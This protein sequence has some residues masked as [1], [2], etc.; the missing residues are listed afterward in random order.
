MSMNIYYYYH[1][2]IIIDVAK[3][4]YKNSNLHNMINSHASS[5]IEITEI[6]VGSAQF[7]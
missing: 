7:L 4:I 5:S 1:D 6:D 3:Q 2:T